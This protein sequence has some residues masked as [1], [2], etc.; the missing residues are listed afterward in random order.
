ML[1]LYCVTA[2]LLDVNLRRLNSALHSAFAPA[3]TRCRSL[4]N[5]CSITCSPWCSPPPAL[6]SLARP[7]AT[8]AHS[9]RRWAR[10]GAGASPPMPH[11]DDLG[12]LRW[13]QAIVA[14]VV[15]VASMVW[16]ALVHPFFSKF[17]NW[18]ELWLLLLGAVEAR[19]SPPRAPCLTTARGA[20]G[21]HT[22]EG[23]TIST[24]CRVLLHSR[25]LAIPS[26]GTVAR[27]SHV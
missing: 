26:L 25:M 8:P 13:I 6:P 4:E 3:S 21:R 12:A 10:V 27:T 11:A 22:A 16:T 15:L 7:P 1:P 14:L 23:P 5:V 24:R 18:L 20:I 2:V 19:R 9:G 17:Q